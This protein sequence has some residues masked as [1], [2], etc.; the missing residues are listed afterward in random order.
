MEINPLEL[1][2][3]TQ[4]FIA[5][6]CFTEGATDLDEGSK[7]IADDVCENF[8]RSYF[9]VLKSYADY[10]E[11]DSMG[12][13]F[14]LTS[15]GHGAGFWDRGKHGRLEKQLTDISQ[16]YHFEVYKDT[17]EEFGGTA[18]IEW[19]QTK[20]DF[21]IKLYGSAAKQLATYSAVDRDK[22]VQAALNAYF[23]LTKGI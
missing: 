1:K 3:L 8:Y 15:Q 10:Q 12:H 19:Y 18:T 20:E 9:W 23:T 14:W 11:W 16:T 21:N 2:L 17:E 6:I 4:G 7:I 5:A 22:H 13:D